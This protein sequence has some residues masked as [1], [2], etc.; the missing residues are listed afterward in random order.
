MGALFGA[1]VGGPAACQLP[2]TWTISRSW[3]VLS[4]LG[5][6]GASGPFILFRVLGLFGIR[7]L[8]FFVFFLGGGGGGGGGGLGF[9]V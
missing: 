3:T 6:L 5:A 4:S 2:G 1:G 7:T 8:G 9:R